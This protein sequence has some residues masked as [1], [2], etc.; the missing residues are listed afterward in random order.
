MENPEGRRNEPRKRASRPGSMCP[1]I[2]PEI[3]RKAI[4]YL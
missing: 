3:K 1:T 2:S 4:R